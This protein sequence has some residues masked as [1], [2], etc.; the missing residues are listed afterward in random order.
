MT[1]QLEPSAQPVPSLQ[2]TPPADQKLRMT[3]RDYLA[4]S[5]ANPH[6]PKTELI[7]GEI[8]VM[9]AQ[10]N[11]HSVAVSR[12]YDALRAIFPSPMFIRQQST[13]QFTD[14]LL[15]EPDLCVLDR[16]PVGDHADDPT[17]LLCVEISESS[18]YFDMGGKRLEYAKAGVPE[19]WVVDLKRRQIRVFRQPNR[20]ATEPEK[21]YESEAIVGDGGV[22][23]PAI[24]PDAK[25]DVT[26]MIPK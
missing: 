4:Y 8:F 20:A 7:H 23:S 16:E 22:V 19:Y 6:G 25:L 9:A 13:H 24:R 18:L 3:A 14:Y 12:L 26:A 10:G 15:Y 1:L 2:L 11:R 5:E 17:P 21:A